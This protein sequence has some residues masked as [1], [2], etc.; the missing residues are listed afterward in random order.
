MQSTG[1][2]GRHV[3]FRI[4]EAE[5]NPERHLLPGDILLYG[6]TWTGR[7]WFI[8]LLF[9]LLD[10]VI[11]IKTFSF[12]CH[13]ERYAGANTRTD[14]PSTVSEPVSIAARFGGVRRFPFRR[15]GLRYVLRPYTW[16]QAAVNAWFPKIDGYKYDYLGLLCFTLAVRRGTP[17]T[18]FCSETQA[19]VGWVGGDR[20]I[21]RRYPAD[22]VAPGSYLMLGDYRWQMEVYRF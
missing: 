11:C 13:V 20:A 6:P 19:H 15:E 2:S 3:S 18:F 5:V 1:N 22:R 16:N 9:W 21:N 4:S 17:R 14:I 8:A 10:W 12:V 7:N